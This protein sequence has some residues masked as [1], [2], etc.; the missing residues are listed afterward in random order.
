MQPPQKT[1]NAAA[2]QG[3]RLLYFNGGFWQQRRLRDILRAAGFDLA[4]GPLARTGDGVVVWGKSPNARRG[5][6]FAAARG[7]PIWRVEDA[8][9]R[10][11]GLGRN[12]DAPLGLLIDPVG[13][14]FD[15]SA[16]SKL[17]QILARDPLDDA[18]IL[19]RAKAGMARL[20]ALDISK[21]NLHDPALPPPEPGYVLVIDQTR[22]DASIRFGMAGAA[23]FAQMLEAA[24]ADHPTARIL[25]KTHPETQHG[26]RQGHFSATD[27]DARVQILD[28]NLSPMA[29]LDGAIA[30]YTVSSQMGLE[31]ILAGH[32]P[33]VFGAPFYAGWGLSDD[34]ISLPRRGRRLTKAQLFAAAYLIAPHWYNPFLGRLCSFEEMVDVLEAGLRGRREDGA[35]YVAANMRAWKRARLQAVFGRHK[36]M[37]F[38]DN[39]DRA[40][41]QAA[42]MGRKTMVWGAALAPNAEAVLR[43]EDGFVRSTGLG[44]T[45]TPPLSLV[46]DDLGIYYDPAR[47]SRFEAHMM[48]PLAEDARARAQVLVDGLRSAGLTKYNLEGAGVDL[49]QPAGRLRILVAGQVEDDASIRLG[50]GR[51]A[52]GMLRSNLDLLHAARAAH[53]SAFII[54]KPH[55]DVEAGLRM[56]AIDDALLQGLADVIAHKAEAGQLLDQVD[57][58]FTLTS[59]YGFE[60]LLRGVPV[61]CLGAPF[62]AGWGLTTDLGDIPERRR[63]YLRDLVQKGLPAPDILQLA[64]AALIAYPRYY[65]PVL[66]LNCPPEVALHRLAAARQLGRPLHIGVSLRILSKLQGYFAGFAHWWR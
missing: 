45:L 25:I 8:F 11:I 18:Q 42:R 5:E 52:A 50:A 4:F 9:I 2:P 64:H 36:P 41:T 46:V 12:G 22:G 39:I 21:Y 62:Y 49:P 56:G 63:A 6:E 65:D 15:A 37:I 61:T 57:G 48:R 32:R 16:P 10:S 26:H 29:A 66:K 27:C 13:V 28:A 7:L 24:R 33:Q 54:Y 53:P 34:R 20:R 60:A 17:E 38:H 51:N 3:L 23:H 43:V 59:T 40:Q 58:L 47:P 14:H 1:P 55:P 30:V 44:A 31:A 19:A 35:G